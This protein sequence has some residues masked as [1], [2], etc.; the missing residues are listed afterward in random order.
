MGT[1]ES[2][3]TDLTDAQW[4]LLQPLLPKPK[5]QPNGP[6]RQPADLRAV[7]NGILYVNRSGCQWRLVPKCFGHWNTVYSYFNR[8]SKQ[9]VWAELSEVLRRQERRRQ[10]RAPEPSGGCVDSQSVKT[11]SYGDSRGYDGG[12]QVKGR[13][14]HILVDT[15]GLLM[16]VVVTAANVG[17]REG[18]MGLLKRYFADGVKRLRKL[19]VDAG[20]S[21]AP[22]QRWVAALKKTHKIELEVVGRSGR[23]FQLVAKR[24]V[25]ERTFGWFN[26]RRRLS[27]DYEI[28]T[29]NSEAMVYV[30]SISL[31]IK[32]NA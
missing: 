3:L 26:F 18:L 24:W 7:I 13:K 12:K 17:D 15:L 27:K 31:L 22:L 14:R 4:A 32:R 1:K 30:A 25:V 20:Y 9:G 16:V 10:G 21:G 29:R 6:G 23:G 19:W 2:Y 5:K 11:V 28:L 8:W